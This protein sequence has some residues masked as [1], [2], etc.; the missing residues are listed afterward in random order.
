MDF[1]ATRVAH[2]QIKVTLETGHRQCSLT[3]QQGQTSNYIISWQPTSCKE[4]QFCSGKPFSDIL[5]EE[6][7]WGRTPLSLFAE[8]VNAFDV[9]SGKN[10]LNLKIPYYKCTPSYPWNPGS[11]IA[12]SLCSKCQH[13]SCQRKIKK[14]TR[15]HAYIVVILISISWT[16]QLYILLQ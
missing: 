5:E 15:T 11:T 1:N 9:N 6:G 4:H 10:P 16:S 8:K 12:P 3:P 14:F 7:R 2:D 13:V